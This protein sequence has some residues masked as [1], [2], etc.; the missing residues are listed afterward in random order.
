MNWSYREDEVREWYAGKLHDWDWGR[1]M[2][3]DD[4]VVGFVA[5]CGAHVDQIF[6]D[7]DHQGA[8]LGSALMT[9]FLDRGLRPA[10][11]HVFARNAPTRAYY[12]RYGFREADAWWN[13]QEGAVELLYRLE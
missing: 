4:V 1:V 2:C 11:L 12:E 6:V 13:E 8:G 5:A 7:P 3:A 10:T 9:A